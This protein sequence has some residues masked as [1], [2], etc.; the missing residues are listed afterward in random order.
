MAG[1]NNITLQ[2]TNS[3]ASGLVDLLGYILRYREVGGEQDEWIEKRLPRHSL[4]YSVGG[5]DCGTLYEFSIAAFNMV[6]EGEAGS[7]KE[8]RTLGDEPKAPPTQDA[9]SSFPHALTLHLERWQ[10]GGCPISH[11]V[12]ERRTI[13]QN[14]SLGNITST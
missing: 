6:G 11:F 12:L 7:V 2:W 8:V 5:L 1:W 14:W 9:F 4:S 10:D 13:E 3:R